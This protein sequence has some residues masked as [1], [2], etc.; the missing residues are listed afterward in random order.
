M[1]KADELDV[2]RKEFKNRVFFLVDA[3]ENLE[4][5]MVL[6]PEPS[7]VDECPVPDEIANKQALKEVCCS[8]AQLSIQSDRIV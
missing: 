5:C 4:K 8:G 6:L 2:Q 3:M 1:N 7:V